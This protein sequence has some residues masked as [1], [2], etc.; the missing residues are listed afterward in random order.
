MRH[1]VL[2][3]ALTVDPSLAGDSEEL[4]IITRQ[5]RDSILDLPVETVESPPTTGTPGGAK[6]DAG[7]AGTLLITLAASG[8]VITTLI[9]TVQSYLSQKRERSP[10]VTVDVNGDRLTVTGLSSKDGKRLIDAW[11]AR[12]TGH[13]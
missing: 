8:G 12:H 7:I 1:R 3:L 2:R 13:E 4:E 6:G 10:T 11:I 9:N 5:L